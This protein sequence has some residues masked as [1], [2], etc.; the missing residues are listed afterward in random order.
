MM[1]MRGNKMNNFNNV[2]SMAIETSITTITDA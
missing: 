1:V 2:S